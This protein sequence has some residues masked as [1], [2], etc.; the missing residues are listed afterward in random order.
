M[1][2][3]AS[4]TGMWSLVLAAAA[5]AGA[6][7]LAVAPGQSIQAAILL[8]ADGDTIVLAAGTY[9]ENIDFLGKSVTLVGDGPDTVIRGTGTGSV[10][11]FASGEGPAAVLDSVTVRGGSAAAGGGV[12]IS[13][14][15]PTVIR[16]FILDNTALNAG[17]GIYIV[18]AES[19]PLIANNLIVYNRTS[20]GDP[21]AIQTD[22]S[23][24]TILNNTVAANDSNGVFLAGG[25]LPVVM[26]NVLARNGSRGNASVARRGRGICNFNTGSVIRHNLFHR[27]AKSALLQSGS[28]FRRIR[29]AQ[30]VFGAASLEGNVDGNPKFARR[31]LARSIDAVLP[32]DFALRPNSRAIDVGDPD[33]AFNDIDGSRNTIGQ[34]GGP[35]AAAP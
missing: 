10:V 27:N 34:L 28:D 23:S 26:N 5:S 13:D 18:G 9:E 20:G 8:A 19:E 12:L 17:S 33:P 6:A 29:R 1:I 7:T 25:G 4:M 15:S 14:A 11:R 3:I 31:R 24:P 32:T 30:R 22:G 2:R 35:L 21:H 16:S